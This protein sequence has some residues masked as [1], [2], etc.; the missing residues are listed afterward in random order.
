MN[1][2][3]LPITDGFI[4]NS[5]PHWYERP[6]TLYTIHGNACYYTFPVW[7]VLGFIAFLV[8]AFISGWIF[9]RAFSKNT[10]PPAPARCDSE[11]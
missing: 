9:A 3:A 1:T 11:T 10:F 8:L 7:M 2:N 4:W 5:H 6:V